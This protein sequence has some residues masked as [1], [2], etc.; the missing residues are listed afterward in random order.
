MID[1]FFDSLQWDVTNTNPVSDKI[2][3]G[4]LMMLVDQ[5]DKWVYKGS[6]TTPPCARFVYWNV[7]RTVYPIS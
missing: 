5:G 2:Y 1:S 7:M 6:V 3:Y 4:D